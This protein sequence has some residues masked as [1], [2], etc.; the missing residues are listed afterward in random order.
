MVKVRSRERHSG[1]A[2]SDVVSRKTQ[3]LTERVFGQLASV[4]KRSVNFKSK[5]R[6]W[7]A[8]RSPKVLADA[9]CEPVRRAGLRGRAYLP[10]PY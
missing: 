3:S 10:G 1:H 8:C 6:P 2:N 4:R 9:R 7:S 5:K